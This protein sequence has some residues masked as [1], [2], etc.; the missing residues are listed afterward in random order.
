MSPVFELTSNAGYKGKNKIGFDSQ[1]QEL[2]FGLS[3]TLPITDYYLTKSKLLKAR[4]E[5][6]Q[7]EAKE[8]NL[9]R[10]QQNQYRSELLKLELAEKDYLLQKELWDLQKNRLEDMNF[11]S[12]R[13]LFDK[14]SALLEEEEL[15]RRELSREQAKM[16]TIRHKYQLDLIE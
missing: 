13:G 14:S 9:L 5:I 4:E 1:G 2:S 6:K 8:Y 12:G 3:L 16:K 11:V 7:A 10:Q 15:L